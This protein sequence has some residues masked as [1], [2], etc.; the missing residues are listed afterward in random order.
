[1]TEDRESQIEQVIADLEARGETWTNQKV[2]DVVGGNYGQLSQYLKERRALAGVGA[3]LEEPGEAPPEGEPPEERPGA[4]AQVL[5]RP[6]VADLTAR[7][8]SEPVVPDWSAARAVR[9]AMYAQWLTM[10]QTA[11]QLHTLQKEV[12]E[13]T[14]AVSL[15]ENRRRL[16]LLLP[17]DPRLDTARQAAL[18]L[19]EPYE[20]A[21]ETWSQASRALE[22]VRPR[23]HD[24][25]QR[26]ITAAQN[27]W[28]ER[29]YPSIVEKINALKREIA[30]G[31]GSRGV[32]LLLQET[33]ERLYAHRPEA[34]TWASDGPLDDL[35]LTL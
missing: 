14:L 28:L 23:L 29:Q 21:W 32:E 12:D 11:G 25:R 13:A 33:R 9:T 18:A 24:E 27:H 10:S 1:M 22:A 35:P 19:K 16:G 20:R 5:V 15:A 26:A 17:V 31:E 7:L 3:G 6:S 2:H 4:P 8:L 34:P 30:R